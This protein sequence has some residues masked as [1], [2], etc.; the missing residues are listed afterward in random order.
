M[1]IMLDINYDFAQNLSI[2]V[3]LKV[4]SDSKQDHDVY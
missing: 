3:L 4:S 2:I 1:I